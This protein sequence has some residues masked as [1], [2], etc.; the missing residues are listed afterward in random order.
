VSLIGNGKNFVGVFEIWKRKMTKPVRMYG[1]W[2]PG[3]GWARFRPDE[4]QAPVA[5][6]ST[7]KGVANDLA[8]WLQHGARIRLIDGALGTRDAEER[9]KA[10]EKEKVDE[11]AKRKGWFTKWRTG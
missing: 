7:D 11:R 5:W 4:G 8:I 10:V 2:I 3:I 9:L 1:V 6:A